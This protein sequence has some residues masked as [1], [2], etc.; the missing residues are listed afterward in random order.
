M[1]VQ[2]T[3]AARRYA[4][5][6]FSLAQ[7]DQA[8]DAVRGELQGMAKLFET[9]P[10]LRRALFRP[11]HPVEQRR[12]VLKAVG[13]QLGL[14]GSVRNFLV[15][16][17]DQR[18]LVDFDAICSEFDRLAD[19][20]AGLVKA[21]VRAA[22]PLG[23]AQRDRLQ[24]ALAAR[25]GRQVELDVEIDPDL[26]GGAV[27]VVGNVVFDGSLKTQLDQLRDTLTRGQ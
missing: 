26:I 18:R 2:N 4:R 24:R 12:G 16:L 7:D 27:A 3:A 22:A 23:D 8:V 19:E 20:A 17:I 1:S 13:Q 10:S 5:A 9:E 14:S 6:L 11:L 15:Y 25:T 21:R